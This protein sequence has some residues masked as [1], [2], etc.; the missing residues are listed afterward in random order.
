LTL[1]QRQTG[2]TPALLRNVIEEMKMQE[3]WSK[4]YYSLDAR[5]K[6]EARAK[7]VAP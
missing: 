3:S 7:S 2:P 4:K 5:A 6:I 1:T